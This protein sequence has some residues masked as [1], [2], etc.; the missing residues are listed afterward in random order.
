MSFVYRVLK[1]GCL[2]LAAIIGQRSY[3][4][5]IPILVLLAAYCDYKAQ[6]VL[7]NNG[8][9]YGSHVKDSVHVK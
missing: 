2:V 3:L 6:V 4:E 1:Y 5:L 9:T 7:T 8:G